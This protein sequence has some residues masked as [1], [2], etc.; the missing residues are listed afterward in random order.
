MLNECNIEN[1]FQIM[2]SKKIP[3]NE[4]FPLILTSFYSFS[5]LRQVCKNQHCQYLSAASSLNIFK[6][7]LVVNSLTRAWM[8]IKLPVLQFPVL[9]LYQRLPV[10]EVRAGGQA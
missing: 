8:A 1:D 6:I 10:T 9:L 7:F 5:V 2:K 4:Q 3:Y